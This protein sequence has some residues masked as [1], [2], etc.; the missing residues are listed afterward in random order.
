LTKSQ[1]VRCVAVGR[2][3]IPVDAYVWPTDRS[4]TRQPLVELHTVGS[5]ALVEHLLQLTCQHGARLAGAGEFT[6]RAFLSGRIDLPQAEAVL[7]V[8]D[9]AD[10]QSLDTALAQLAGGL[11]IPL[12]ALR[13]ELLN[14]LADLE[15]GLDFVEED[16][17]F[18][19]PAALNSR[20]ESAVQLLT[21]LSEQLTSRGDSAATVR[22]VLVGMANVGKSSLFN[23][24]ID[25]SSALVSPIAGTTRDYLT[26]RLQW[27]GVTVELVDTAGIEPVTPS[28]AD[29]RTVSAETSG[30]HH[31]AQHKTAQQSS[32]A[33]LRILCLDSSRRQN[34][35][36][37]QQ[38]DRADQFFVWTKCDAAQSVMHAAQN[39]PQTAGLRTSAVTGEGLAELRKAI[40]QK[41]SEQSHS[42][43]VESTVL[44]CRDS[45]TL[46]RDCLARAVQLA[47]D[48]A[49]EELVA[50]EI[51]AALAELGK[52]VGA[53]Y[54]N[55]LLDRIF[56]R[57]CIGK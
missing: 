15:A 43:A 3:A 14:L 32:Q 12:Q 55:D 27:S 51:R 57:F 17:Q 21:R 5:P 8:I 42:S 6:L 1:V 7:G 33:D 39:V 47:A 37:S 50:A 40:V 56:S 44:R 54:T 30:I 46:A 22:V 35:W 45:L 20:L 23:A 11:S 31:A 16:I 13:E 29:I 18:V 38:L 48:R 53:V 26:C 34:T 19:T 28:A 4:Y 52:V 10:R 9:S 41:M 2:L 36:E 24:L 49:G 25:Q